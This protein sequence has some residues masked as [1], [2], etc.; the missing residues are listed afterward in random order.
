MLV[1][2][3]KAVVNG[4][5]IC[6]GQRKELLPTRVICPMDLMT[7][8]VHPCLRDLFSIRLLRGIT[9]LF[10]IATWRFVQLLL[11]PMRPCEEWIRRICSIWKIETSRFSVSL[12]FQ[13]GYAS[14]LSW[15]N[16][17][18][19]WKQLVAI[20]ATSVVDVSTSWDSRA[21]LSGAHWTHRPPWWL[22][23]RR[24]ARNLPQL[25]PVGSNHWWANEPAFGW[26]P[27]CY[28]S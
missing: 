2:I 16:F 11:I 6:H 3:W 27:K 25:G 8:L 23:C 13:P 7:S 24:W 14:E 17:V 20:V 19:S 12:C 15:M 21:W 5:Y 26:D 4:S 10:A 18:Y 22:R 1:R 28:L 9:R